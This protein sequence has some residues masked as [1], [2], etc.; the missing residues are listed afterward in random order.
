MAVTAVLIPYLAGTAISMGVQ[1]ESESSVTY[2]ADLYVSANQFG[3]Q[4]PVPLAAIETITKL[5]GVERV[6]PRI[7]GP[8]T[9]GRDR[10]NAGA[11]I[12]VIGIE[13]APNGRDGVTTGRVRQ[14]FSQHCLPNS[15]SRKWACLIINAVF[16]GPYGG[17]IRIFQ[18]IGLVDDERFSLRKR[19][20]YPF[21]KLLRILETG[22]D[23]RIEL[24]DRSMVASV[25]VPIAVAIVAVALTARVLSRRDVD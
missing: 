8:I 1:Q 6:T 24:A 21:H 11:V 25:V 7:V 19:F 22:T 13:P 3:Q 10:H 14:V 17:F 2:G 23:R 15:V 16:T 12:R 9:L 4:A 20:G 5:E 18:F